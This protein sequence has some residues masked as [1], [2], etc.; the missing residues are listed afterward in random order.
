[1]AKRKHITAMIKA[2]HVE[3]NML[4]AD[5]VA[6]VNDVSYIQVTAPEVAWLD[7]IDIDFTDGKVIVEVR[8]AGEDGGRF[9]LT[10]D[11]LGFTLTG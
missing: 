5:P 2:A 4:P 6:V 3:T 1:M 9:K 11:D 7:K 10:V 8:H